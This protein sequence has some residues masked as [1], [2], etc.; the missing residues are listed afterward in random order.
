MIH[1]VY[2]VPPPPGRL[3]SRLNRVYR[4]LRRKFPQL[5]APWRGGLSRWGRQVVPA[6]ASIT[7]HLYSFLSERHPTRL[8]DLD[9]RTHLDFSED[10]IILGHPWPDPDTIVQQALR[11]PRRCRLKA[12]IFPIHH[13]IPSL[14]AYAAPLVEL[15][16]VVFGI[17]GPYWYD[18]LNASVFASW[19]PKII[20]LDMAIDTKQYR[21]VKRAFNPPGQRG[22]LYIGGNRP[23]KGC[24]ILSQTMAGLS[25]FERGWIGWGEEM[26]HLR[27]LARSAELTPEFVIR[28]TRQ[29]DFFVN[30]SISDANPA[31]ILEAMAWG[32]P[33]ACTP[34]SGYYD[35][36]NL[37]TL[38]TTD[39]EHNI[40]VLR[41]L[42]YVPEAELERTSQANAELVRVHYTWDRFCQTV[43]DKVSQYL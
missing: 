16:D 1:F 37:A 36:P 24:E 32:F 27:R 38:S 10:D 39:I 42:Q 12:L 33:V 19:K 14:N 17:M 34:Q 9:E 28:L 8:Y 5:P 23:E 43:W 22:Y 20:R 41:K 31:T 29:Y 15:A 40:R 25:E 26:P 21:H 4:L 13:G 3:R 11:T 6:P 2:S 18:T 30:T 35:M 7:R